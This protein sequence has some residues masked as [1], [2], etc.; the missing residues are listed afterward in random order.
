M[1]VYVYVG[2]YSS[3]FLLQT[4]EEEGKNYIEKQWKINYKAQRLY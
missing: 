1:L 4:K 2:I 3:I